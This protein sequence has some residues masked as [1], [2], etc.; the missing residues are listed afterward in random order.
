MMIA[1]AILGILAGMVGADGSAERLVAQDVLRAERV[2][3]ALDYRAECASAGVTPDPAVLARVD[4]AVPSLAVTE[5]GDGATVTW[6][7][8]WTDSGDRSRERSLTV[9]RAAR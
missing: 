3:V 1:V 6:R 4:G 2:R 5:V 8:T 7:A 9:F